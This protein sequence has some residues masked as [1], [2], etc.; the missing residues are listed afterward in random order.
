MCLLYCD[1]DYQGKIVDSLLGDRIIPL[2]QYDHFFYL[3]EEI[4]TVVRN[5]PNYRIVNG[6]LT[7]EG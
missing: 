2:K 1:V 7:I 5:L 4:D 6:Q 3:T